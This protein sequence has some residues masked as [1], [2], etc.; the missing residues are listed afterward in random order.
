MSRSLQLKEEG[1][2]HFQA[3]DFAGADSLYS[4]A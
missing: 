2:R 3:G 1:N 4:Q